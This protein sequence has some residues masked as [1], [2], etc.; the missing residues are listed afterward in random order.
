MS[1]EQYLSKI[2][3]N[4]FWSGNVKELKTF[5]EILDYSGKWTKVQGGWMFT[6]K[7]FVC[8]WYTTTNR[9]FPQGQNPRVI[10][11]RL[12]EV[13]EIPVSLIEQREA[14]I[15]PSVPIAQ[16]EN[17][18][19]AEV[20][21]GLH[22]GK[23]IA[24]LIRS[25]LEKWENDDAYITIVTPFLDEVGLK[26][27][28]SNLSQKGSFCIYTREKCGWNKKIA[29]VLAEHS[30]DTEWIAEKIIALKC[31]PSFHAKFLAGEYS[32]KVELVI[33]SCN[34]TKEHLESE[35]LETVMQIERPLELFRENWIAPLQK[36]DEHKVNFLGTG[37]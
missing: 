14:G 31:Q 6:H 21:D 9:L 15:Q 20:C 5:F 18:D 24:S 32:D 30:S 1:S 16:K 35:Q 3:N 34:M 2:A 28:M 37:H 7:D 12:N 26:F 27:I 4:F 25:K 11:E 13:Y 22:C 10:K 29:M 8:T 36:M 23:D 19:N 33:T 17:S